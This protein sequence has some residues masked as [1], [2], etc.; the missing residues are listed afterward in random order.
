MAVISTM[1]SGTAQAAA[2]GNVLAGAV[3]VLKMARPS[4]PGVPS[5]PGNGR[6]R[7]APQGAR[8]VPCIHRGLRRCWG[9]D[10]AFRRTTKAARGA[11]DWQARL[12]IPP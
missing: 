3:N 2:V 8:V 5:L 11:S 12:V 9:R 1:I 7:R 4:P 10:L 6:M